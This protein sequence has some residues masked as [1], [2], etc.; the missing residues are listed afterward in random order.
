MG[1]VI[2]LMILNRSLLYPD[3][4]PRVYLT[5]FVL[6]PYLQGRAELAWNNLD[7]P[8]YEVWAPAPDEEGVG[9]EMAPT[10]VQVRYVQGFWAWTDGET[11]GLATEDEVARYT[12]MEVQ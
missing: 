1:V 4:T 11:Y 8:V 3:L 12:L 7:S 6:T 9:Y 5:G 2:Y 10:T